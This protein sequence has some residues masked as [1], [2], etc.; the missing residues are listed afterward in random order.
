MIRSSATV[1]LVCAL[2]RAGNASE[3][4]SESLPLTLDDAIGRAMAA[5]PAIRSAVRGSQA[6]ERNARAEEERAWGELKFSGG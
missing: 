6:L 1:A 4:P 3:A 5:N 2:L